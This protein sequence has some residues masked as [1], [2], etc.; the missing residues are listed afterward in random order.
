[1][2]TETCDPTCTGGLFGRPGGVADEADQFLQSWATWEWKTFCRES[3]ETNH[4]TSQNGVWGSCKTGYGP[5]W[6]GNLPS[7]Q[8]DYARTYARA[9]AGSV[10]EMHFNVTTGE[11]LLKYNTSAS[12]KLPTE[13]Y[14]SVEF[15]YRNNFS[16][17][18]EPCTAAS[19]QYNP[20][21]PNL[22]YVTHLPSTPT[23][24]GISVVVVPL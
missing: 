11:F 12:C 2:L 18:I 14:L 15:H 1:M 10:S 23:G 3:N 9:V 5:K 22:L 20:L 6:V 4:S 21:I 24:T 7:N 16:V 17:A 8:S 19:Y 13:I